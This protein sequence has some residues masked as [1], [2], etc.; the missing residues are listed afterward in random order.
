MADEMDVLARTGD[1]I[2]RL[3]RDYVGIVRPASGTWQFTG[4]R[5]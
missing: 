2:R 1:E 4:G 3:M 5:F